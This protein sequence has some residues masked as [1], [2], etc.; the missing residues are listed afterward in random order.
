MPGPA[1]RA[2]C[3]SAR[4]RRRRGCCARGP[5]RTRHPAS[6]LRTA[7]LIASTAMPN[8]YYFYAFDD[9]FGPFLL[10][11]RSYFPY[12]AKCANAAKCAKSHFARNV[13]CAVM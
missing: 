6:G 12:N 5:P 4:T 11:F 1:A 2:C 10:K 9:D 13:N 8:A 3:T 7:S